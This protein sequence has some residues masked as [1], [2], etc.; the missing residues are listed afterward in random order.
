M[1]RGDYHASNPAG[2]PCNEGPDGPSLLT[3]PRAG[4]EQAGLI[5]WQLFSRPPL[6]AI[7]L[8]L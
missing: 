3:A 1:A 4:V 6:R 2:Q 5:K 8:A 7:M